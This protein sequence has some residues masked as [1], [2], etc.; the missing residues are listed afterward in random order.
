[1]NLDNLHELINR[2]EEDI[3]NIY[4]E[5]HYELFK[6]EAMKVWRDEWFKPEDSFENFAERFNAARRSFSLFIDNSRMHPSNGVI[7]LWEKEPETI[8]QLELSGFE[9][10][11]LLCQDT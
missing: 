1:M 4:G 3:D 10:K 5:E 8:L 6:W 11:P 2:Y 9:W 7:R